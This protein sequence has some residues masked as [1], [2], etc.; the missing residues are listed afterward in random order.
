MKA[1]LILVF[2][3]VVASVLI[4]AEESVDKK[5]HALFDQH[6]PT[7]YLDQFALGPFANMTAIMPRFGKTQDECVSYCSMYWAKAPEMTVANQF[8]DSFKSCC[9]AEK[10]HE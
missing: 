3:L 8:E 9:C 10:T 1:Q 4:G 6:F 7:G 5:C 2:T